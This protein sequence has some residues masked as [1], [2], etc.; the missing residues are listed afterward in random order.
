MSPMPPA[1][2]TANMQAPYNMSQGMGAGG[3]G[4]PGGPGMGGL[5]M[6]NE[7]ERMLLME[8]ERESQRVRQQERCHELLL[9]CACAHAY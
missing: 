8:K 9:L 4:G 6:P 7:R 5:G 3:M 1:P 2:G